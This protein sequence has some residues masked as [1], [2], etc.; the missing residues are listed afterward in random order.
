MGI[1]MSVVDEIQRAYLLE[2]EDSGE[3]AME[4]KGGQRR[5]FSMD[6]QS[7]GV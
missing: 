1:P 4:H 3:R 7:A 2:N 5:M 6:A